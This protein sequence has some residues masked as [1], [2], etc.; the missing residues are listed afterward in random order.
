MF[1]AVNLLW[2][3]KVRG[4]RAAANER[5]F[6]PITKWWWTIA[7][8]ATHTIQRDRC[9]PARSRI[10]RTDRMRR[11]KRS[12]WLDEPNDAMRTSSGLTPFSRTPSRD[13]LSVGVRTSWAESALLQMRRRHEILMSEG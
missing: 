5:R 7:K 10:G 6:L 1:P 11:A 12:V 2:R 9:N 8:H 13:A 3:N 4:N